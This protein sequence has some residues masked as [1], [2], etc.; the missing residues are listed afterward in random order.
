MCDGKTPC[1]ENG[2]APTLCSYGDE[3][4]FVFSHRMKMRL[5]GYRSGLSG[6]ALFLR[7]LLLGATTQMV[8]SALHWTCIPDP[9]LLHVSTW[10]CGVLISHNI[11]NSCQIWNFTGMGTGRPLCFGH[12]VLTKG[13]WN[14]TDLNMTG[15]YIV[16][17]VGEGPRTTGHR[18]TK[19]LTN[20]TECTQTTTCVTG[21]NVFLK[22]T[23]ENW[24]ISISKVVIQ[25]RNV[26]NPF[27]C[28]L[29]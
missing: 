4:M 16:N 2:K 23:S 15:G 11:S 5:D 14:V 17:S 8:G 28:V 22:S 6:P 9:P 13:C 19:L 7:I 20:Q 12:N 24:N 27:L 25:R 1:R 21:P 3:G 26:T 10:N 29:L 18:F